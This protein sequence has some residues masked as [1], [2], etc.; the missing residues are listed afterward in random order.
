VFL[1]LLKLLTNWSLTC[2]LFESFAMKL[3]PSMS[4]SLQFGLTIASAS[5]LLAC[6]KPEAPVEP[7][8]SVKVIT[9]GAQPVVATLEY[10]AEVRA[11]VESSL[12]FRVG[13]KVTA[14]LVE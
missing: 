5:V 1:K 4:R 12:G 8:R 14:R 6:S 13:G 7:I 10:A 11:R 2:V 9:V 3:V